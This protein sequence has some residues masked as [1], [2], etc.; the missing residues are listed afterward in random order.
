MWESKTLQ[1]LPPKS[2]G[3]ATLSQDSRVKFQAGQQKLLL[4]KFSVINF[5]SNEQN[6]RQSNFPK[7]Q[8]VNTAYYSGE[9]IVDPIQN[10]DQK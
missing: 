1:V 4:T 5:D 7:L 8:Y 6:F 9:K 2:E 10:I 3:L